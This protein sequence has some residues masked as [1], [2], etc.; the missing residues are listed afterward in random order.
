MAHNPYL[1]I[2]DK[3]GKKVF[4]TG[5]IGDRPPVVD[6]GSLYFYGAESENPRVYCGIGIVNVVTYEESCLN[7]KPSGTS[8]NAQG[9]PT[10]T[11]NG[12]ITFC[13][14]AVNSTG[15]SKWAYTFDNCEGPAYFPT[16]SSNDVGYNKLF[17]TVLKDGSLLVY[18]LDSTSG[19]TLWTYTVLDGLADDDFAP[20]LY[21]SSPVVGISSGYIFVPYLTDM[22]GDC[23][24][25]ALTTEGD[26]VWNNLVVGGDTCEVVVSVGNGCV[27]IPCLY[28]LCC[29]NELDGSLQWQKYSTNSTTLAQST[30]ISED[31]I[32]TGSTALNAFDAK[33][34]YKKVWSNTDIGHVIGTPSMGA[35]GALLVI[36]KHSDGDY[37]LNSLDGG[38]A[39]CPMGTTLYNNT[40]RDCQPGYYS[41]IGA[42]CLPC[43]SGT[44]SDHPAQTM[45]S[46]CSEGKHTSQ[47]A[48]IGCSDCKEMKEYRNNFPTLRVSVSMVEKCLED[49][50]VG[51]DAN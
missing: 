32:Y 7:L 4:Q 46:F 9:N 10:I 14:L 3:E 1:T 30:L 19:V 15:Y 38:D 33:N 27:F 6:N 28:G 35:D 18:A 25:V 40:C 45:C 43:E 13:N 17:I 31:M 22:Y 16:T 23:G 24:I 34:D 20:A 8:S 21:L 41:S 39:V 48:S 44:F 51:S 36:T 5:S 29:L 11:Q 26:V 49:M 42:Y 12:W 2:W 37:V 50:F 47:V